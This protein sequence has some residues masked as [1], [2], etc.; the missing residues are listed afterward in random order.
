MHIG[1]GGPM[2]VPSPEMPIDASIAATPVSIVN[3]AADWL[4]SQ[5]LREYPD[6]KIALSEGG[7]GWIPYFLERCDYV[8]AHHRAWT[9][10]DFG[11]RKPSDVFREHVLTCFIDDAVGVGCATRSGSENITWECDYPH[12]D[13]DLADAPRD[14]ARSLAGVPDDEVDLMTHGNAM[15]WF[16]LD[17]FGRLGRASCTVG[18]LRAQAKDVDLSLKRNQGGS[19]RAGRSGPSRLRTP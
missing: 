14:V 4:F 7:I 11:E 6:L 8:Y 12:S 17:S 5:V 1:T 2:P 15:R 16:R 18:A 9:H 3:T 10:Q 19:R 13:C